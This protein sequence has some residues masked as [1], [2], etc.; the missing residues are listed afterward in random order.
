MSTPRQRGGRP[1]GRPVMP[2]RRFPSPTYTFKGDSV[3]M[4]QTAVAEPQAPTPEP[5]GRARERVNITERTV[6]VSLTIK[7]L[8]NSRK[9]PNSQSMPIST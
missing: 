7:S 3:Y 5:N 2:Q 6:C 1:T 9:V 4:E 8:G